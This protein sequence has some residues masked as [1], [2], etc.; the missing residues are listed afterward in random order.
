M[1]RKNNTSDHDQYTKKL[2]A[3][4]EARN[5]ALRGSG[6]SGGCCW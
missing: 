5:K 4:R 2:M 3:K 6:R 1:Q